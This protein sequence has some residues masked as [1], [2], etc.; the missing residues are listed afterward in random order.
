MKPTNDIAH[1][2]KT[3]KRTI[4]A[5]EGHRVQTTVQLGA[6]G[7][8]RLFSCQTHLGVTL[9]IIRFVG[10]GKVVSPARL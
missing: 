4:V 2:G 7:L 8:P 1:F 5:S 9:V 6:A 10:S 3:G